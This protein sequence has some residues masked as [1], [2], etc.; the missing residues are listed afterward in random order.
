MQKQIKA[1]ATA[2]MGSALLCACL[3]AQAQT[4]GH[5]SRAQK[6]LLEAEAARNTAKAFEAANAAAN[7]SK[8]DAPIAGPLPTNMPVP[9]PSAEQHHPGHPNPHPNFVAK[10]LSPPSVLKRAQEIKVT[11]VFISKNKTLAEVLVGEQAH[12]LI[13]GQDVPQTK[14]RVQAISSHQVVLQSQPGTG[15]RNAK[16]AQQVFKLPGA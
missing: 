14:W 8:S 9:L 1:I 6:N 11:G 4:I 2:L 13:Q 16:A 3:A 12:L 15:K 10:P 5:Y 7:P